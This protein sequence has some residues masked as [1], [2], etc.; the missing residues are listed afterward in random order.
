[1]RSSYRSKKAYE[2]KNKL[3][4]VCWKEVETSAKNNQEMSTRTR[5]DVL[6]NSA[7]LYKSTA[8]RN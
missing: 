5:N 1:M 7:N 4:Y 6:A 3:L 2:W 8:I